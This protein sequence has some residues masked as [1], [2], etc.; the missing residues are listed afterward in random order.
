MRK[1]E[2]QAVIGSRGLPSF[3]QLCSHPP[4]PLA[5][6]PFHPSAASSRGEWTEWPSTFR[7]TGRLWSVFVWRRR[8]GGRKRATGPPPTYQYI[9]SKKMEGRKAS[10]AAVHAAVTCNHACKLSEKLVHAK[11]RANTFEEPRAC[12]EIFPPTEY[13]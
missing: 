11:L 1:E 8:Q 3:S 2:V 4:S 10:Q 9:H 5:H 6:W 7:R 13:L 12:V